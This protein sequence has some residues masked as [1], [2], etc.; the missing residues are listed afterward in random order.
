MYAT[1]NTTFNRGMRV[2]FLPPYSP[3]F[4]PIEPSFSAIKADIRRRGGI[5]RH[6]MTHCED[7]L[8][9]YDLLYDAIWSVTCQDAAGWFRKS[10]YVL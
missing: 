10:G 3:D 1:L 2:E 5:I 6:A 4:N 9:I 7:V 8:D